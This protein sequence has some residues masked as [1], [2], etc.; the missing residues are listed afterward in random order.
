ML[1]P[2]GL[3][4][5]SVEKLDEADGF[6]LRETRRYAHSQ[7]YV[8]RCLAD[9]GFRLLSLSKAT[10]RKDRDQAV[11]GMIVVATRPD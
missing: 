4:A 9:A 8:E 7:A 10:I 6:A 3:F 2:G 1:L 11:T 5:F